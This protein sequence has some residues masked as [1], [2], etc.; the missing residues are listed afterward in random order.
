MDV[1]ASRERPR[2]GL[3][4]RLTRVAFPI[5]DWAN[6]AVGCS[7]TNAATASVKVHMRLLMLISIPRRID[8]TRR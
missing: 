5:P 4:I 2:I 3:R 8:Q 1:A 6:E 7:A